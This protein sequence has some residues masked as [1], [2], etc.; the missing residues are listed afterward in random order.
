MG[1]LLG[2]KVNYYSQYGQDK[3]LLEEIFQNKNDGYYVDI[4]AHDGI[5]LSNT[6]KFEEIGWDGTIPV[7]L[8]SPDIGNFFN[9]DGII[10]L[11]DEFDVSEEIYYSKMS[12]IQDNLERVK[13]I[14]VLE[15]FIWENYFNEN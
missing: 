14:E 13:K 10:I 9:K 8:G 2:T 1:H 15:D 3:Y 12:V 5:S 7:Y 11:S 4:G 6:K